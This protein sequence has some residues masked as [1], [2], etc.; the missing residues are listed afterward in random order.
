MEK[1]NE[2]CAVS[3]YKGAKGIQRRSTFTPKSQK[4]R[5]EETTGKECG[6][7]GSCPS[8]QS[9]NA[10]L[11]QDVLQVRQKEPFRASMS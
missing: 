9:N 8:G 1:G 4:Q 3:E 6:N 11:K 10:Q 5:T 2:T 7:C